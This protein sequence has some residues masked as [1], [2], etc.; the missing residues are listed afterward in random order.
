MK[1]EHE[2]GY[3]RID[4]NDD[5]VVC[6]FSNGRE[7]MSF[8]DGPQENVLSNRKSFC[9]KLGINYSHLIC[10][11]QVH[12]NT[13]TELGIED[14]G[15]GA[16][17]KES[18][19]GETDA[20]VTRDKNVPFGILTADCVPLFFFDKEKKVVAVAHAGYK[21]TMKKI[22]IHTIE[23]MYKK[24]GCR[25]H[26]ILVGI[27]PAIRECCYQVTDEFKDYF[28]EHVREREG[29][30]YCNLIDENRKQ[31][32]SSGILTGNILDCGFCTVCDNDKFF[33][34]RKEKDKAGRILSLIMLK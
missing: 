28:P 18:A 32:I 11:D 22:A 33:S 27:G 23:K 34:F 10:F 9:D 1:I 4:F 3:Y 25:V 6:A 2:N 15:K 13:I 30:L 26:N 5:A 16:L 29:K 7:N 12:G 8:R 31:L 19:I 14:R 20:G 17:E 24:Y 21:G